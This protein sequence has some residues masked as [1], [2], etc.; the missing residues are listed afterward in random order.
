M[1]RRKFRERTLIRDTNLCSGDVS[2][3][4]VSCAYIC[5]RLSAYAYLGMLVL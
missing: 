2:E 5:D 1:L 3:A 4:L